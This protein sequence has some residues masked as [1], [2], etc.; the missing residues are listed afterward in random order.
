MEVKPNLKNENKNKEGG[1]E[2]VGVYT[3]H[4]IV[5]VSAYV[6]DDGLPPLALSLF[7]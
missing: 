7:Q 1:V 2:G 4:C 5:Q 6:V 3:V